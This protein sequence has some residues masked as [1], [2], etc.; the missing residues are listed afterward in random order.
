MREEAPG[1]PLGCDYRGTWGIGI[2]E[3]FE[4]LTMKSLGRID[5]LI[6]LYNIQGILRRLEYTAGEKCCGDV[7]PV[8]ERS[9]EIPWIILRITG[10]M[11]EG[12]K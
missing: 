7:K 5:R 1:K 8:H 11:G 2:E 4:I 10:I 12:Y 6:V 3:F 9:E